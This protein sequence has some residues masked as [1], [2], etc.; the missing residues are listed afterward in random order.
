MVIA[1]PKMAD[2]DHGSNFRQLFNATVCFVIYDHLPK[3]TQRLARGAL[4]GAILLA[5]AVMLIYTYYAVAMADDYCR[6]GLPAN[7]DWLAR[8]KKLYMEWSGRWA[9]HSL[10][11]LTFPK[12][13]ITSTSYSLLLLFSGPIW[14]LIFYI[15]A[16]ILFGNA[17]RRGE[18]AFL[19]LILTVIFWA[20]MPGPGET[21]YW[22]TG[23]IE[24]QIPFLLMSCCLL[25]L[26]GSLNSSSYIKIISCIG[27]AILAVLV[28]GFNELIGLLL[29]G[30]LSVGII[31]SLFWRRLDAALGF[32][33]VLGFTAIGLA[34]N[35]LAPGTAVHA[36][37]STNPYNFS[38]AIRLVFLEPGQSPLPWL[39]QP[40]MLWFTILVLTSPGFLSRLPTWV[41]TPR[42][43]AVRLW[44]VFVPLIGLAAVHLTL[45]AADYAQ[46]VD[47]PTRIL[48]IAYAVFL[49]GWFASLIPVGLLSTE[50]AVP[51]QSLGKALHLVAAVM[52][53]VSIVLGANVMS[54]LSSLRKT[55]REF[56]PAMAAR[57]VMMRAAAENNAHQGGPIELS[58]IASNPKLFFWN[59]ITEDPEDWRNE[60][61]A[62]FYR[63]G[64]VRVSKP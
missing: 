8:V 36:A 32:A 44:L 33:S 21:W 6:A 15:T 4:A 37:V 27:A 22:L 24:Y 57:Q 9:V 26:T 56:A 58:P 62:R 18:K 53:P 16:H 20:S 28:T 34:V 38:T 1:P 39:G 40:S 2:Y 51:D 63:V 64:S 29:L 30:L 11:V 43:S 14:F 59:D 52:L 12:I 35:V 7:L 13:A 25:I 48:N 49:I 45:L 23:S 17:M 31:L 19:A 3:R 55:A 10:Y 61:F 47:A 60:C 50:T 46:G 42:T 54:G 5:V 41:R